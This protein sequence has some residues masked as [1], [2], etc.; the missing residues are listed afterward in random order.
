MDKQYEQWLQANLA[1]QQGKTVIVTGANTGIGYCNAQALAW[2][3][4]RVVVA[5]RNPEKV[6]Q[7]VAAIQA[8]APAGSVEAGIVDLASLQ[9]VA[10]F[11][12]SFKAKHQQLHVLINN[13]GVMMPPP[14]MT[15]E[16]FESQ[17]GVNFI[18]HFALTG[19]LM[20]ILQA[21]PGSRIVT[22]SSIAHR[23]GV[24]DFDNFKLEKAYDPRRE[25]YQS[26]LAD[27]M[28][29]LELD[30]RLNAKGAAVISLAS[31]PGFTST[32]L[33]RHIDP[34]L[35]ANFQ[36]MEAWQGSLPTLVAATSPDAK[37][38]DYYGPDGE[39]ETGGWPSLGVISPHAY[40]EQVAKRLWE[41]AEQ[42]TGIS[43]W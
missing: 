21:T 27:L 33:Q 30:R 29:A 35:L 23:P 34:A 17:F 24:I 9:S 40:D 28:F 42:A 5:G 43:Y 14:A 36:L 10:D 22:L 4:A 41:Y 12:K 13:A 25:Y 31:H 19:H 6:A 15:Q 39:G 37:G 7:A 2:A 32:D 26:K 38:S 3:G 8:D 1:S 18:G 16:G 20:D 11:A